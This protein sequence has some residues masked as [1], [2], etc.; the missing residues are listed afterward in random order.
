LGLWEAYLSRVFPFQLIKSKQV[1]GENIEYH[2]N[3]LLTWEDPLLGLA[4]G[5][6]VKMQAKSSVGD[7]ILYNV[8]YTTNHYGWRISPHDIM[9]VNFKPD[10]RNA[11]FFGCSFAFGWGIDDDKTLPFIFEKESGGRYKS[12]NLS[13]FAY[14]PQ[15]MLRILD[16]GIIDSVIPQRRHTIAIYEV[17]PWHIERAAQ[18][19]YVS[20]PRNP[21]YLLNR[22]GEVV[23]DPRVRI[24]Y[25][26]IYKIM[27]K[28]Y[29]C[30]IFTSDDFA[31]RFRN[32]S[33]IKLFLQIVIES[34]KI[35]EDKYGGREGSNGFYILLWDIHKK[36]Y[37]LN[38]KLVRI[39]ENAQIRVFKISEILPPTDSFA[40]FKNKYLIK[41]GAHPNEQANRIIVD[42][43]LRQIK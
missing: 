9:R 40:E 19:F 27:H 21:R 15:Q 32:E 10:Y 4:L 26:L 22:K 29:L 13:C 34:K 25:P 8:T 41:D 43:L 1:W 38:K 18:K 36:D 28:C 12:F 11:L 33:D 42:Y 2:G 24:G 16:S 17:I 3:K 30:R 31:R 7:R 5:Q 20:L 35:F 6:D 39:F 23:L 37:H 14:G